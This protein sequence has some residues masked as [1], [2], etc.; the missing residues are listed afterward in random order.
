MSKVLESIR[1]KYPQYAGIS[2][3]DLTLAIGQRYPQYLQADAAFAQ[4]FKAIHELAPAEMAALFPAE[5]APPAA[6]PATPFRERLATAPN[7][8][9]VGVFGGNRPQPGGEARE[10]LSSPLATAMTPFAVVGRPLNAALQDAGSTLAGQPEYGGNLHELATRDEPVF[11][12]APLPYQE[13]LAEIS[14]S[15]PLTA[16]VGKFAAGVVESAPMLAIMPQ[17]AVGKLVAAGFTVDMLQA[18]GESATLLGEELGKPPEDRDYDKITTALSGLASSAAFSPLTGK[19]ALSR[20]P[21]AREQVI[22]QLARQL[23]KEPFTPPPRATAPQVREAAPAAEAQSPI[24][25]PVRSWENLSRPESPP[26]SGRPDGTAPETAPPAE[27]VVPA[28]TLS[29]PTT[30]RVAVEKSGAEPLQA[31]PAGEQSPGA[32]Q[33]PTPAVAG[34][35]GPQTPPPP[36][37]PLPPEIETTTAIHPEMVRTVEFPIAKLKLSKDVP[38]FKGGASE[39]TGTV[40]G[41]EL[42]GKYERRGTAP[43][44]AWERLNGEV[45]IITGRH[46]FDLAKRTGEKTIPT[47]LVREADG[48]TKEMALTFDA[49]AN[50]RDGQGDVADYATYFKGTNINEAEARARGL[51]SRAKGKA[52]WS[53]AKAA[54]ADV[55]ALWRDGKIN[56]SQAVAIAT[57]A[58]GDAPAQQIGSKFALQGK[59]ADFLANVIKA[60]RAAAGQRAQ[61]LD[62]FGNDDAAMVQM[63]AHAERAST[64]QRGIAEQIRAVQGAA[65]RPDVARKLGVDVKD[66]AGI[67]NKITELKTE[68]AR[69]ENWPLHPDL[70]AKVRGEDP[71]PAFALAKPESVAEQKARLEAEAATARQKQAAAAAA[72]ELRQKQ[73]ARLAGNLGEA[74]QGGL[75][76]EPGQQEIFRPPAPGGTGG[77]GFPMP[78]AAAPVPPTPAPPPAAGVTMIQHGFLPATLPRTG[79]G[80]VSV[81]QIMKALHQVLQVAGSAAGNIRTGHFLQRALGIW[82][83]HQ[84]I[85][86][87]K[88]ADDIPTATHE[89]GHGL[90]QMIYGTF[91]AKGLKF[92]SPAVRKELIGLGKALYGG[93]KPAAG[94]TGEGFA[95]FARYWLTTEDAP[96]V[97]PQMTAF[98]EKSFLPAHPEVAQALHQARALVDIW[99]RQGS[100]ER[101]QRQLVREPGAARR[102]FEALAKFVSYQAQFESGAPLEAVSR[103]AALKRGRPLRPSED[104]YALFSWKR[105]SA[106]ATVERMA[107]AH[108]LDV[109][110]NPVGP[111]LAEAL[112]PVKG[113]RKEFTLYLFARRALERW[114][115][116]QNPGIAR[117]DAAYIKALWDSPEFA[118]A[119]QKYYDWWDGL[120]N[121]VVQAD[122][123]MADVVTRIRQGS[124]DYAPLARLIDP[125]KAR[126]MAAQAQSN[127]FMRMFGSGLPVKDIFDQTFI[128]AARLVSRANRALVANSLV[129]LANLKGLGHIIEELPRDRVAKAVNIEHIRDQ[130]ESMGVDTSA[131]APDELLQ[132][133]A[134]A[135]KPKGSAPIITVKDAAGKTRWY[136]VDARLY[137]ALEGLQTFSLKESFPG[138]PYLGQ[139]LD[140]FLGA[141]ARAFRLGTTGLRP[142]FS[143][144]TN[145]VRD[146]ATLLAQT[147]VNPA[148][149][150]ALYPASLADAIGGGA[151]KQ[152][153]YD[154]G[155]HLGQ[156]LG[157]DIGHTKRISTGLFHGKIMRV[158]RNPVDHLRELFSISE[159]APRLAEL[160]AVADEV[161]WK[162]GQKL[163]PDQAVQLALAAKRVTVDFS[164]A[165]DVSRVLNQAVPFYNPALQG[166]RSFARAFKRNPAKAT[167]IGLALFTGPALFNWWRNKDKEWYQS[168]TWRERY[169][170]TNIEDGHRVWQIPRPFEWGNAFMVVPEALL[171]SWYRQDPESAR[172]ALTHIFESTNPADLPVLL[173]LSKEQWQNRIDFWDRPIV[174][175]NEVDL[176]ASE[177]TGPYTSRLA[178]AVN[179]A[180]PDLSP[181]RVDAALRGYFGGVGTDV[182]QLLGLGPTRQAREWEAGDFPVFGTIFRRGGA[183]NAQNQHINDFW[184]TYLPARSR[185]AGHQYARRQI[186][187]GLRP[188]DSLPE[189]NPA[190]QG[191]TLIGEDASQAIRLLLQLAARTT[192]TQ[193][194]RELYRQAGEMAR[195]ATT[196]MRNAYATQTPAP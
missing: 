49:E 138:I 2:D 153:F 88:S 19:H 24:T 160:R 40:A 101:A 45:E 165:G 179:K 120:L 167:L 55:Y 156:P 39:E 74:G 195:Q 57:A 119:A 107:T 68:L 30:P 170:Y 92:L 42:S 84:E 36:P 56:E 110:G 86:R 51:L 14:R 181:R 124:S 159:S 169:L 5:P 123:T 143:M 144:V 79:A 76:A 17:G 104:P 162:P 70:V 173:Q 82:R 140:L 22:R 115:K 152:A 155:A 97:A 121:Y 113:R 20:K 128:N 168:L 16:T 38:N 135:D 184:D 31:P 13:T 117:E 132:Y 67:V 77:V 94:Y 139:M 26:V 164:A 32:S 93:R 64:L 145:P 183:F 87:L 54:T 188:P 157:L 95:E 28:R 142:A 118:V 127:P 114:D 47:Q 58:P 85:V 44:V 131:I 185:V 146:L 35:T 191:A 52:G 48:F 149:V 136:E 196:A 27:P 53:L 37:T 129:K 108:M 9:V 102:L 34:R 171:D 161:G 193:A 109:W 46:R 50:I 83:P 21:S 33:T 172:Q 10:I 112:A 111:S 29:E 174:P 163:S 166:M 122:P 99:R 126:A 71:A 189:L 154:L 125:T 134:P 12:G 89:I 158:V 96:K 116:N 178:V 60:S 175:R 180:F 91:K 4:E 148:K 1:A 11:S 150:A 23:Q 186:E 190:D 63:A 194:R 8:E 61:A 177:Q 69:W 75:F 15:H 141:P 41:Q 78:A 151:Y 147:S 192:E 80:S 103:A 133:Y 105:G 62:L 187:Q 176:P 98:F 72:E 130:L 59:S 43:I 106:G 7:P 100:V 73:Q 81:P 6:G 18:G 65:K 25:V 137:E 66:P 182:M 90:Q 3:A